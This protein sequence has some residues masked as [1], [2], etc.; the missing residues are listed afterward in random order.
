MYITEW[1]C[2]VVSV[3]HSF[4]NT[5]PFLTCIVFFLIQL[6]SQGQN[7]PDSINALQQQETELNNQLTNLQGEI[8]KQKLSFWSNRLSSVALPA[9]TPN[10]TIVHHSLFSLVYSEKHEQ[11]KWVAHVIAPEV[12]TGN[13]GRSNDFRLDPLVESGTCT[14][15]DYFMRDTLENGS[16]KYDGFGFDRGH[17]AP[18]ADFRWSSKAL[19]ESF[20]YS[21]MS[22][23]RAEFNRDSWA[24][25]ED[26]FRSYV[27][28]NQSAL[29]VLTGPLLRDGLPRIERA[30]SKPSIPAYFYKILY[31]EKQVYM[32]AFLMPN[33]RCDFAFDSYAVS[34]DSLERLTG[35][36]FFPLLPDSLEIRL[37][38]NNDPAP[39]L[40][41]KEQQDV[42]PLDPTQLG[43]NEFN[44]LQAKLYSGKNENISVCGTVVSTKRSSKGNV[45]LNL[46]KAFPNQIFTVSIFKNNLVNFSYLPDEELLGQVI[47][48]EGKVGDF[49]GTPSVTVSN[50]K[51]IRIL[52]GEQ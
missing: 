19:S 43:R 6:C 36:D 7:Y 31:D 34:V 15:R 37:E 17:L 2:F 8:E 42:K 20:Y 13:A 5:R 18:S 30:V 3:M 51:S 33:K 28:R 16:I 4:L 45:F 39:L 50:E 40:T 47:C 21:N 41:L 9:L 38:N 12:R 48:V 24:K 35:I 52:R 25:L 26:R 46:D 27:E 22:P 32:T 23:Q 10:E 1:Y 11:A 49:N 14:D 44:T 29:F